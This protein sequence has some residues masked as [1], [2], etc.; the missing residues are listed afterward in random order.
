MDFLTA[1]SQQPGLSLHSRMYLSWPCCVGSRQAARCQAPGHHCSACTVGHGWWRWLLPPCMPAGGWALSCVVSSERALT[2]PRHLLPVVDLGPPHLP[3]N[4]CPM[5]GKYQL[6]LT[7]ESPSLQSL[8]T[9][10]MPGTLRMCFS[11]DQPTDWRLQ[12]WD[13]SGCQVIDVIHTT[14]FCHCLFQELSWMVILITFLCALMERWWFTSS[15]H[16]LDLRVAVHHRC[17][18]QTAKY[19]LQNGG[20]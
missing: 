5:M 20:T 7:C 2:E 16:M 13:L 12:L 19:T 8:L 14:G 9:T 3:T 10:A 18:A 17:P 11:L 15:N 4:I 1:F 6:P